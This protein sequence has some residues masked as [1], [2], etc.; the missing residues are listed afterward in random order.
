ME[1][2][3]ALG[4]TEEPKQKKSVVGKLFGK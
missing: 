1:R 4:S 3:E 2:R